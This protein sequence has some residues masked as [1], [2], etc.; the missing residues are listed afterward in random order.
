MVMRKLEK[1]GLSEDAAKGVEES[2]QNF[3]NDYSAIVD[4]ILDVKEADIMKV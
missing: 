3:T 4:K 1:D 2:I